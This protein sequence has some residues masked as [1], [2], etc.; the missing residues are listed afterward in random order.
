MVWIINQKLM[1]V[2]QIKNLSFLA[3][4]QEPNIMQSQRLKKKN[5]DI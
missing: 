3:K 5:L 4:R 2:L 1:S